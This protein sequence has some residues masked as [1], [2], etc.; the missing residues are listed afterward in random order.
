MV[1][2]QC[3]SQKT[4][5]WLMG[6]SSNEIDYDWVS[7][8]NFE[9]SGLDYRTLFEA[10]S[11]V[12]YMRGQ[13]SILFVLFI[14]CSEKSITEPSHR[15][16]R[17]QEDTM[18]EPEEEEPS[19]SSNERGEAELYPEE[20]DTYRNKKRMRIEHIKDSMILVSGG[21]DWIVDNT[22]MWENYS[23]TLG[24]PDFQSR[25]L[26][27]R[28]VSV[29]FQKFLEDAATH[30]CEQWIAQEVSGTERLFFSEIEPGEL[31]ANKSVSIWSRYVA[32]YTAEA[33]AND[34][35]IDALIDLHFTVVQRTNS[36]ER[37]WNTVCVGLF[38]HPD[39]YMY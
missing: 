5:V 23:A 13:K 7:V 35:M 39:F 38:T 19:L 1:G 37:A 11:P 9:A 4:A 24:V 10:L 28:S 36:V 8:M 31:D 2:A 25:V 34:P 27:D 20:D 15:A 32:K 17:P 3:A 6:W 12:P 33:P 16:R 29:M 18:V 22:D 30:T 14:G 26:E 21:V